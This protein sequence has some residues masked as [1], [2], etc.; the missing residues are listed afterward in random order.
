M[1]E[2]DLNILLLTMDEP[3]YMPQYL[4]PILRDH[5]EAVSEVVIA[6]HP[7]EGLRTI[8]RQ[9]FDMFG[10]MA[11][12]RYGVQYG[13]G[14]ALGSLPASWQQG[15]TDRY[16]SV[17]SV[18]AAS[19]IPVR[20]EEDINRKCF[21][22]HVQDLDIDL[23]LSIACGQKL[24][25]ELLEL[26]S[27]GAINLH[28]SLLPKYRGRATAFWVLYHDED[29][30]GVT[31]HYMTTD[32]DA[33]DIVCQHRFPIAADD[34]MHDVYLKIVDTGADVAHEV[35][36]QVEGGTVE[37]RPNPSEEGEYRSLPERAARREFRRRE[38]RFR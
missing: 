9:R 1:T 8:L 2:S 32:L 34:T 28:G 5:R 21:L 17:P 20:V 13:V 24:D 30:S 33:G 16:H 22:T 19:D 18:A 35:I 25:A 7:G 37:T 12:L 14:T 38:N 26:P 36:E 3:M 4:E 15:L 23:I 27:K 10:P 31:A 29:Y 11:F 6:P